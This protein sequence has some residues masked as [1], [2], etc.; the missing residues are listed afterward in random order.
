[1]WAAEAGDASLS[2]EAA[3][4]RAAARRTA[5]RTAARGGGYI[6]APRGRVA[7][8]HAASGIL[9]GGDRRGG[10]AKGGVVLRGGDGEESLERVGRVGG[11]G[12]GRTGNVPTAQDDLKW[13]ACL[14]VYFELLC[15][16]TF[17]GAGAFAALALPGRSA[18]K[19]SAIEGI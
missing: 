11:D 8:E 12:G 3:R 1:M 5:A 6:R 7:F 17:Y 2:A 4:R 9:R 16:A 14:V 13:A 15:Q 19:L 10:D 18:S